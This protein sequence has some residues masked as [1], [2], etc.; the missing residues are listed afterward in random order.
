MS[1]LKKIGKI[2]KGVV[3][4]NPGAVISGVAGVVGSAVGG[5]KGKKAAKQQ[6]AS[7]D[8]AAENY[9]NALGVA[10]SY[11]QPYLDAGSP[12]INALMRVNSGDY[13]GFN[14]SPDY[15]YARDEAL[16]GVE[17]GAAA[18]GGLYS[19]QAMKRLAEVSSGLASQ[20][21]N[22][23][24]NALMGQ[25]GIG[26]SAANNLGNATMMTAGNVGN[27]LIGAGDARA[28]GTVASGNALSSAIEQGAGLLGELAVKKPKKYGNSLY[29]MNN[30]Q[31]PPVTSAVG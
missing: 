3:T 31:L 4:G 5:K 8:A 24:R 11:Q 10:T 29:G 18:R 7:Q 26:Q 21:L 30:R 13:S 20:N 15:M 16:R 23:Y 17:G 27:A 12:A 6:A 25:I 22:N 19:G 28:S 14:A 1:L 9:R 2:A